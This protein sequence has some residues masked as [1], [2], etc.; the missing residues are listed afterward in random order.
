MPGWST[1]SGWRAEHG[2]VTDPGELAAAIGPRT[3]AVLL[4]SPAM[5]TGAVLNGE[6]FD[7]ALA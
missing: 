6:R 5:P 2:W 3:A 1:A 7:A 4:M